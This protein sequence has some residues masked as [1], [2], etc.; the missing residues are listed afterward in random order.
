MSVCACNSKERSFRE[1][2]QAD[3]VAHRA[4]PYTYIPLKV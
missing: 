1:S 4:R 3:E 2:F